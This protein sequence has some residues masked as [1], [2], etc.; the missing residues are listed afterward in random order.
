M[1]SQVSIT[2]EELLSRYAQGE[3]DFSNLRL[4]GIRAGEQVLPGCD[5]SNSDFDDC[6]FGGSDMKE[7]KFNEARIER[8]NFNNAILIKSKLINTQIGGAFGGADFFETDLS[9]ATI[10]AY[11]ED[12]FLVSA[13]LSSTRFVGARL[14]RASF[15]NNLFRDTI[16]VLSDLSD[17]HI[18]SLSHIDAGTL[19]ATTWE[20]RRVLQATQEGKLELE[21]ND[22]REVQKLAAL[23]MSTTKEFFIANGLTQSQ[24][25]QI[26]NNIPKIMTAASRQSVFISYS[27]A[28]EEFAQKLYAGLRDGGVRAW[29]APHDMRGGRTIITQITDAISKAERLILALSEESMRSNWVATEILEARRAERETG[30]NKLF[31]VRIV[32][33]EAIRRWQL[34]HSDTGEDL[35]RVVREYHILD[36]SSWRDALQMNQSTMQL[37]RDLQREELENEKDDT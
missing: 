8:S 35:A 10:T 21:G 12:A 31:P 25:I 27:S 14:K 11:L 26:Y 18:T 6:V 2:T 1:D 4:H 23:G 24:V 19:A 30:T 9:G 33:M 22:L 17:V 28:D 13:D 34:F 36:F 5:F 7:C 32:D 3:R 37:V 29:F 16:F 20:T 15:G